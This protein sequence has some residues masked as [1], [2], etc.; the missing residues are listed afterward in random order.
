MSVDGRMVNGTYVVQ[1]LDKA[2]EYF[3][4]EVTVDGD[5]KEITSTKHVPA[6]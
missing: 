6:M 1:P 2:R 4:V 3:Y 5:K